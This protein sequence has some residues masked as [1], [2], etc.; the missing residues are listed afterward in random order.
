MLYNVEK[1]AKELVV[2]WSSLGFAEISTPHYGVRPKVFE[3]ENPTG[4]ISGVYYQIAFRIP[5]N[6][7]F[8]PIM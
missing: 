7:P 8:L 2:P 6:T 3:Y 5:F 4:V 1:D